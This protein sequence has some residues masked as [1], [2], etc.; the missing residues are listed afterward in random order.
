MPQLYYHCPP[1]PAKVEDCREDIT[2]R[3]PDEVVPI[4]AG[5]LFNDGQRWN[6][7]AITLRRAEILRLYAALNAGPGWYPEE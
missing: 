3:I 4:I 6:V 5:D 7:G 2:Y 1:L